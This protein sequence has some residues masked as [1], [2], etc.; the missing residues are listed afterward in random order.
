MTVTDF[1]NHCTETGATALAQRIASYWLSRGE[2]VQVRVEPTN[3]GDVWAV[4]SNMI[5]GMPRPA[6]RLPNA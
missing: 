3:K 1:P 2:I 5:N 6:K 4:R